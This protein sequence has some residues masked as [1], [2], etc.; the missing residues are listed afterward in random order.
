[1]RDV[2]YVITNAN[3][4]DHRFTR[5]RMPEGRM[6]RFSL[7]LD[8]VLIILWHMR[9]TVPACDVPGETLNL[10]TDSLTHNEFTVANWTR[11]TQ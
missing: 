1:M 4:G 3:F 6:S 9:T 11:H 8:V 7:T 5:F 10:H 2:G